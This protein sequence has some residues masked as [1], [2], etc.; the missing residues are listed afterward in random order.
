MQYDWPPES[1][2]KLLAE[3]A[4]THFQRECSLEKGQGKSAERWSLRTP[5]E[6]CS[7]KRPWHKCT[8]FLVA[9]PFIPLRIQK[10]IA[11]LLTIT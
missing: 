9:A 2:S 8:E 11:S 5:L 6:M 3:L 7:P 4:S 10:Y 1:V